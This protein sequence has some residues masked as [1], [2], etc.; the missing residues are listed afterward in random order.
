MEFFSDAHAPL[1]RMQAMI[2][3]GLLPLRIVGASSWLLSVGYLFSLGG[4]K[5]KFQRTQKMGVSKND[6]SFIELCKYYLNKVKLRN[7]RSK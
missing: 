5:L 3:I 6:L 4:G 1:G 2:L 7:A